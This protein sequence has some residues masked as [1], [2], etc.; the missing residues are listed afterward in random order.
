MERLELERDIDAPLLAEI[1]ERLPF[2][3]Q[4][5]EEVTLDERAPRVLRFRPRAPLPYDDTGSD[6]RREATAQLRALV[7]EVLHG[8]RDLPAECVAEHRTGRVAYTEAVDAL[9]ARGEL[10]VLG[11]G[12]VGL[13]GTALALFHY[14]DS[15]ARGWARD[16]GAVEHQY[17]SLIP[18]AAL[19]RAGH[20]E[21]FP[22]HLTVATHLVGT[23]DT[24]RDAAA[25]PEALRPEQLATP[26]YALAPAVCY[27]CYAEL[28][29]RTIA[30]QPLVLSALGRCFRFESAHLRPLERLW[31]FAMREIVVLGGEEEVERLRRELVDRASAL[32]RELELDG[33]VE[34]ATDPFFTRESAGRRLVQGLRS[35]KYELRLSLDAAGRTVA[36][37]SFNHHQDF[38][39]QRFDIRQPSGAAAHTGC[40]AFGLE[41]WVLAFVSQH[42]LDARAWPEP[43]QVYLGSGRR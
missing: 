3:C 22:Q 11:A 33:R 38:F 41:R 32:L 31:D 27:H 16:L 13:S 15:V 9:R 2:V 17:P 23:L 7:D 26:E 19:A 35:L 29:G 12:Q 20:P 21:S 10:A 36:V 1:R 8:R 24:L 30:R 42:G 39:G 43:V 40:V 5:V 4:A 14:F 25:R 18:L 6:A 34:T 28:Q 37:A